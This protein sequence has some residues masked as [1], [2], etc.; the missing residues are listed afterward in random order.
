MLNKTGTHNINVNYLALSNSFQI[1]ITATDGE[2]G[3]DGREVELQ[4]TADYIQWRY[5]GDTSWINLIELASLKGDNGTTPTIT[6]NDD[7]Y[8]V[9]NGTVTTYKAVGEN[10]GSTAPNLMVTFNVN[11][12][13]MPANTPTEVTVPKGDTIDLPIPTREGYV[14]VGWFSGDTVNDGQFLS[15]MGVATDMTL[16][17]KWIVD[18]APIQQFFNIYKSGNYTVIESNYSKFDAPFEQHEILLSTTTAVN[19]SGNYFYT[20]IIEAEKHFIPEIPEDSHDYYL[21]YDKNED[22]VFDI[23]YNDINKE[24]YLERY[25]GEYDENLLE[26]LSSFLDISLFTKEEGKAI[27][28]YPYSGELDDLVGDIPLEFDK[29]IAIT[30]DLEKNELSMRIEVTGDFDDEPV[31]G[32]YESKIKFTEIGTTVIEVPNEEIKTYIIQDIDEYID[33]FTELLFADENEVNYFMQIIND[34]K[35][36][37]AAAISIND[38]YYYYHDYEQYITNIN[39]NLSALTSYK[40]YIYNEL[41][42]YINSNSDI[43]TEDSIAAMAVILNEAFDAIITAENYPQLDAIYGQYINEIDAVFVVDPL[44]EHF[45]LMQS[46]YYFILSEFNDFYLNATDINSEIDAIYEL[47]YIYEEAFYEAETIEALNNAYQAMVN[48][49]INLNI[50]ADQEKINDTKITLLYNIADFYYESYELTQFYIELYQIYFNALNE[51]IAKDNIGEVMNVY[52]NF[53]DEFYNEYLNTFRSDMK[54]LAEFELRPYKLSVMADDA[55]AFNELYDNLLETIET[56]Y[57]FYAIWDLYYYVINS[58]VY[59]FDYNEIDY[60]AQYQI[61]A[62]TNE[63]NAAIESATDASIIEMEDILNNYIELIKDAT[64]IEAIDNIVIEFIDDLFAVRE[65]DPNKFVNPI[66]MNTAWM[67][68]LLALL[69]DQALSNELIN[70][71]YYH[72]SDAIYYAADIEVATEY[73]NDWFAYVSTLPFTIDESEFDEYKPVIISELEFIYNVAIDN[74]NADLPADFEEVYNTAIDELELIT[75]A[76]AYIK[77]AGT[78]HLYLIMYADYS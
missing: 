63:F 17:A 16:K 30:L 76:F 69:Y 78:I 47:T 72:L 14:F 1:T 42:Y 29:D 55:D 31:S 27:Y 48:A 49:F 53:I 50:S 8:W 45:N 51:V 24:W 25:Y 59:D 36:E 32:T 12:G 74:E 67:S 20:H 38:I 5:V 21:I 56:R 2:D 34:Y 26:Y 57:S 39:I 41:N 13:T 60:T 71:T 18:V 40:A 70:K 61:N 7:G 43:A 15:F 65:H 23:Y 58:Q 68:N 19:R 75:D 10:G 22:Y 6:I 35:A 62:I 33:T 66:D 3:E 52:V 4:T 11:G 44:K 9:I 54:T 64:T 37:I 73:V 28:H 46:Q 77:A